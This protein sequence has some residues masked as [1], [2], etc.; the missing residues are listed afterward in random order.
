MIRLRHLRLRSF[1]ANAA[2]EADIRFDTGLNIIQAP[3]TSGKST[4]LQ[5]VIY[6]L[7]LER[8]LGPQL[9]IPLPYAMRERIHAAEELPYE[10]VLQS[11]VELEIENDRDEIL[12]L[13]RDVV[14]GKD[15][16]LIQ[17]TFGAS[18]SENTPR[19]RQRD[20]YVL[21]GGAAVQEDGFH[22]F[23]ATYLGWSLPVVARYDGTECPLY[24]ETIFPMIFVEQKRGW[25]TIQ[26]PFPT[27]FRIQDI[28]RRVMEFLLNLDVA[29][30]RRQRSELRNTIS[31]LNSRWTQER[32]KLADAA[33]RVGRIRGLPHQPTAEFAQDPQIDLQLF[34]DGEWVKLSTLIAEI[35]E[36]IVELDAAQ[37]ETVD[38][39]APQIEARIAALREQIDRD[40]AVL[41]T[42]R[43]EHASEVQDNQALTARVRSLEVDLRRNQDAQK[44]Q[45]LGSELG[46]ASSDHV[47]PTCHQDVT[48]ELLPTVGVI[49]MALDENIAFVRSQ[50]ELYRTA[51][52]ASAERLQEIAGRF[53]GIER[54]L[55]AKQQELRSLRQELLR[56]GQTPSRAMIENLVRKQNFVAQ[57]KSVDNLA[58]S[59]L[60]ELQAVA[61]AWSKA[62]DTL[63][64]LPPDNLT[65]NDK[66]K[67][68]TLETMICQQLIAYKFRSFQP[69]EIAL[70]TDNF[71]PLVQ[72]RAGKEIVEKEINFEVSASD[73]IRLKWAYLLAAFELGRD[74]RTNHPGLL[75]F[76]EPGQQEIDST[77]LFAF[78]K[79][80]TADT[81]SRGQ[82]I[83]STSEP[84]PLVQSQM[85]GKARIIDFP[86]FILQPKTPQPLDT[87]E[88]SR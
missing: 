72:E 64:K 88:T 57:M 22:F 58:I 50:L 59:L 43:D 3:N 6:A 49:G 69:S 12:V 48:S 1:T 45:R 79:R 37:L 83:V 53:R 78:L 29:Q 77:S 52:S 35:E 7:G 61:V 30:F 76:D 4:C 60:D 33:T 32:R 11:F 75:I 26:G 66:Q 63:A 41:E 87:E 74:Q 17:V 19:T 23:L 18:L 31:E 46:K 81:Q 54:T 80:A 34:H 62:T 82:V 55:Q 73:A 15:T 51:L 36:E 24:L 21:D 20:F 70:S 85:S 38:T 14:G 67:V 28:A 39:V 27:Y 8:A 86:G 84:L 68:E 56:P 9:A 44:L 42:V 65:W 5:A 2:Y 71:R 25:S 13:H 10:M 40:T 47:C 16:K